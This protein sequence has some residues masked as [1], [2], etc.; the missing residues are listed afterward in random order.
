V[1]KKYE[2]TQ[3]ELDQLM[4]ACKPVPYMVM[5]GVEPSSPEENAN[6]VWGRLAKKYKF[7]P[8]TP[9]PADGGNQFFFAESVE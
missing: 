4:E 5:N 2:M 6:R 9:R 8:K 7:D 3:E 1:E